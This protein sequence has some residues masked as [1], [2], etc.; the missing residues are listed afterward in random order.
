MVIIPMA[1]L[2]SRFLEAGYKKPKLMLEAKEKT[3]FEHSVGSFSNY[4]KSTPFLFIVRDIYESAE[5]VESKAIEM[6]ISN[7]TIV[8]LNQE[9]QGQAETVTLGLKEWQLK[10][11]IVDDCPITIFNIDTFR[12]NFVFPKLDSLGDGY[13]EV[14]QG[15]GD[16]WSFVKALNSNKVIETAEKKPI[17]D[18]CCTG[19]YHFKSFRTYLRAYTAYANL[20]KEDWDKGEIYVAPLYNFLISENLDIRYNLIERNQVIFCGIPDEYLDF[21]KD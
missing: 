9:T 6:A 3:L 15:S 14:F 20:P 2:S 1:G 12:P 11:D 7:Y 17:S 5:F 4:F 19:L 16:N 13:L 8:T 18:L 10:N 21:I